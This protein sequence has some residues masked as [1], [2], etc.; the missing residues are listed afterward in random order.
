MKTLTVATIL[1]FFGTSALAGSNEL[2]QGVAQGVKNN[3]NV[4]NELNNK[5][6]N[7]PEANAGALAGARSD[8][9]SSLNSDNSNGVDINY[10]GVRQ[11]SS[12]IIPTNINTADCLGSLGVGGQSSFLGFA[13]NGSKESDACNNREDA[14]LL[15]A[16]GLNS[17]AELL[18]KSSKR[19][20]KAV[21]LKELKE[22]KETFKDNNFSYKLRNKSE[23]PS[24]SNYH[25]AK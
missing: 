14:K 12:V 17:D 21:K 11:T 19:F 10:K 7:Q 4:A 15:I 22:L 3:I 20:R 23:Y 6:I 1:T 8:A 16:M 2:I 9:K 24:S 13:V 5:N 25:L 18:I